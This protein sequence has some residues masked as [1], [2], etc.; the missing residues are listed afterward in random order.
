MKFIKNIFTKKNSILVISWWWVRGFYALGIMKALEELDMKKQISHIYGVSVGAI[1]GAYRSAGYSTGWIYERFSKVSVFGLNTINLLSKKS[2]LKNNFVLRMFEEDLPKQ[3]SKLEIP[4]KIGATDSNKGK[5]IVYNKWNLITPL[6]GSMSIP[7]I[8][9]P[10]PFDWKTLMDGGL[11]N[12]FPVDLAKNDHPSS[13][14]IW[15]FLNKFTENQP[16]NSLINNLSLSYEILMRARDLAKFNLVDDLFYRD[17]DIPILSNNKKQMK[18]IFDL[19]YQDG[20]K[21]FW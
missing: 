17:P 1:L 21:N 10:V 20:L 7:G 15:I 12:N 6:L 18:K 14:I 3:F 8:F 5:Y 4:L 19:W 16:T 9:P 2:L 13:H 11:I